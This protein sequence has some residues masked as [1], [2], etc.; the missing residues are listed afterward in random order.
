MKSTVADL[1]QHL[2]TLDPDHSVIASIWSVEDLNMQLAEA[3]SDGEITIDEAVEVSNL[4][5]WEKDIVPMIGAWFEGMTS[6][7]N[8][9]IYLAML[10]RYGHA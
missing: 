6:E 8:N 7:I 2:Q 10:K 3:I 1:I 4:L 5:M 9:E